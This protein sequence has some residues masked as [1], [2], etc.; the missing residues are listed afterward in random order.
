MLGNGTWRFTKLSRRFNVQRSND[1]SMR[2]LQS[3]LVATEPRVMKEPKSFE[4]S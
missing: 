3:A 1:G 4:L 2:Q